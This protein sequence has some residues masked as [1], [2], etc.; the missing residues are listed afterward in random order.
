LRLEHAGEQ[1]AIDALV[2]EP[3]V[4]RLVDPILPRT[5]WF[6]EAGRDACGFQPRSEELGDKLAAIVTA[7]M[8]WRPMPRLSL[9][10][11]RHDLAAAHPAGALHDVVVKWLYSSRSVRNFTVAPCCVMSKTTS[12]HHASLTPSD[13]IFASGLGGVLGRTAGPT[14]CKPARRR[15]RCTVR[16][17]LLSPCRGKIACTRR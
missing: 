7:Q 12:T 9:L 4:E 1:F 17:A 6:G 2:A 16:N 14:I 8:A 13:L 10:E 15:N 5:A 11:G 3:P